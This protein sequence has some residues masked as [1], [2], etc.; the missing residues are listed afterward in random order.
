MQHD[1][2]GVTTEAEKDRRKKGCTSEKGSVTIDTM[3]L[4]EP[5]EEVGNWMNA[6][7]KEDRESGQPQHL[8][9]N[10]QVV[11]EMIGRQNVSY[12]SVW[13]TAEKVY[14]LWLPV[15]CTS[16]RRAILLAG[17]AI[18]HRTKA[19]E[20]RRRGRLVCIRYIRDETE[21]AHTG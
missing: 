15:K 8:T 20:V 7:P 16:Y 2:G 11:A 5:I 21:L 6:F 14:P 18:Q 12:D 10:A 13:H 4:L 9:D 19:F 17:S 3:E 1:Q